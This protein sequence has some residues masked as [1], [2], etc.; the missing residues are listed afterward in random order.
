MTLKLQIILFVCLALGFLYLVHLVR[1]KSLELKYALTWF[2]LDVGLA[3][4]VLIPKFLSW[5]AKLLGIYSVVNM[6]FLVGF[7]FSIIIIF[8]LTMSISRNSDRVRKLTQTVALNE[9]ENRE[10]EEKDSVE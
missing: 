9:Y 1:R 3:I 2:L 7:V 5:L 10:N 6:V 8:S 4:T